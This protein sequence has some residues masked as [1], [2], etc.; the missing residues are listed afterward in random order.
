MAIEPYGSVTTKGIALRQ[1]KDKMDFYSITDKYFKKE[2]ELVDDELHY[3][4]AVYIRGGVFG[5][6]GKDK[7]NKDDDT[8]DTENTEE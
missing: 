7:K 2:I 6:S 1:P 3:A 4:M 5:E 8:A